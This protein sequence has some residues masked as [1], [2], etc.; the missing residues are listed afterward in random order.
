MGRCLKFIYYITITSAFCANMLVVSQT[1]V[2]SVLGAGLALRGPD[3]SMMTATDGLYE[4]RTSVFAVF[5][6]G[7]ACTLGSV[8]L[9]VWIILHWE[10]ALVCMVITLITCRKVYPNYQRVCKRFG[11]DESE[12]VDFR[13]IFDG[14]A[15]I[16]TYRH[17]VRSGDHKKKT[18]PDTYDKRRPKSKQQYQRHNSIDNS[19]E[20]STSSE[21]DNEMEVMVPRSFNSRSG[22]VQRRIGAVSGNSSA[23]SQDSYG[24]PQYPHI[25]TV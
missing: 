16:H 14:A 25:Q 12:T 22:G 17:K 18:T 20:R 7:L 2:L 1:T 10:A 11:F 9:C 4:E 19:Y 13:D 6:I 24:E 21:D 15:N 23:A 5:G 8:V 3:G